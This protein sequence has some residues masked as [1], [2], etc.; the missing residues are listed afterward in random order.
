[1][2]TFGAV[3]IDPDEH[4]AQ[5]ARKPRKCLSCGDTFASEHAGNRVCGGCKSLV[6]WSTP[7]DCSIA[8]NAAF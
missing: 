1:M 5:M 2:P 4:R 7:N 8:T 3:I 6:A